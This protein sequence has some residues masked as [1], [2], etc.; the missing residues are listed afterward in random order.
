MTTIFALDQAPSVDWLTMTVRD[1]DARAA[2]Y[3]MAKEMWH[4]LSEEG[5]RVRNWNWRGYLGSASPLLSWGTRSDDDIV[6]IKG[7]LAGYCWQEFAPY[8]SNVSR[9]D[10]AVTCSGFPEPIRAARDAWLA[11][12]RQAATH[13]MGRNYSYVVGLNGG[14]TLYV[15]RR[16]SQ[17]FGRLYDKSY[18]ASSGPEGTIWRYEVE[19]K[20][21]VAKQMAEK[22]LAQT[23]LALAI[24]GYVRD[25]FRSRQVEPLFDA[26]LSRIKLEREAKITSSE[27]TLAWLQKTVRPSIIRLLAD[28]K[29]SELLTALGLSSEVA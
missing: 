6:I 8:A 26:K 2:V 1:L 22:L 27:I 15:N 28:G 4:T 3:T 5:Q 23:D 11:L 12:Q 24:S 25:W 19:L 13:T 7:D 29:L 20:K 16:I 14:E 9:I 18:Q 10:L 21:P 17:E